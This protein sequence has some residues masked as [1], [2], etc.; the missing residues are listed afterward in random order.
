MV[1]LAAGCSFN[2][3]YWHRLAPH[4]DGL[5]AR[6]LMCDFAEFFEGLNGVND[7]HAGV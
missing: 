3:V 6:Q 1:H 4:H 2:A 7:G 5:Q